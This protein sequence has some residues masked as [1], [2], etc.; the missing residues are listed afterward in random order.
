MSQVIGHGSQFQIGVPGSPETWTTILGVD[1]IDLGSNKVDTVDVTDMSTAGSARTF[2]GGLEN[3]GDVTVK[4]KVKPGDATQ[5]QL[6]AAKD[7]TVHDFKAIYPG[8]V[9]TVSF[10][11]IISSADES[12][13]GDK[14]PTYTVK[15]Q[16]SGPKVYS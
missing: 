12:I 1:S 6:L 2:I 11:G 9:R 13:P 5:T 7:G 10:S 4:I 8:A 16:I 14:I 15:I 3:S